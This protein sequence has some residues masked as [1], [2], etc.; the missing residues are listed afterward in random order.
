MLAKH[1]AFIL[2]CALTAGGVFAAE[3][4]DVAGSSMT[5]KLP[6]R[7]IKTDEKRWETPEGRMAGSFLQLVKGNGNPEN[8]KQNG[9]YAKDDDKEVYTLD[10]Q[11]VTEI[12]KRVDNKLTITRDFVGGVLIEVLHRTPKKEAK[13]KE[14]KEELLGG[15]PGLV[16][17]RVNGDGSKHIET[18]KDPD[19]KPGTK[20]DDTMDVPGDD[21]GGTRPKP[22]KFDVFLLQQVKVKDDGDPPPGGGKGPDDKVAT[23]VDKINVITAPATPPTPPAPPVQPPVNPKTGGPSSFGP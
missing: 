23:D 15:L 16:N 18:W 3:N 4:P 13:T 11:G 6:H 22:P 17:T 14:E 10:E 20:P 8:L 21:D 1:A 19:P 7:T 2:G 9:P 12:G 5:V